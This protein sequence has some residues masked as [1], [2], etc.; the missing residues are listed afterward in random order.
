MLAVYLSGQITDGD[1]IK[2]LYDFLAFTLN[3]L[4]EVE[5]ASKEN[6]NYPL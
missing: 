3:G 1:E 2:S 6:P 5:V 4:C